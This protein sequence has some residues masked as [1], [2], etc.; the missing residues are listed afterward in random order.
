MRQCDND[1]MRQCLKTLSHY[2]ITSLSHCI[3][4]SIHFTH[5]TP[6]MR[7]VVVTGLGAL[8][9]IGNTVSAYWDAL[10]KGTSGAAPI[11]RFDAEKFKTRFACELKNF[12]VEDYMHRRDARRLDAFSQYGIIAADEA[13]AD[14]DLDMEKIDLWRTGVIWGAGIGGLGT[15]EKEIL[16]FGAGSGTPRY[17]PFMI[18]KMIIDIVP[19]HI[20]IKYGL[21]G[22]NYATVLYPNGACG[23]HRGRWVGSSSNGCWH[24]RF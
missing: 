2:R 18:P 11:T 16:D 19:G 8:T 4:S 13:I 20:S 5:S 9:P 14:S 6:T 3:Y 21:R 1:T 15:L 12:N 23:H 22:I 10:C 17:N 7:R 24:R